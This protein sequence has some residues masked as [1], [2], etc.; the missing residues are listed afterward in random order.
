MTNRMLL[1]E[2]AA[3]RFRRDLYHRIGVTRI[4]PPPLRERHGDLELLVEHFNASLAE[5]HEVPP[6]RF[7]PEV[8]RLLAAYHWPGNVRELRNVVESLLLMSDMPDVRLDELAAGLRSEPIGP[9]PAVSEAPASLE[10]SERA[11]ITGAVRQCSGNLTAA[12]K[13]L[14]VSRST[15]YRKIERY[16]LQV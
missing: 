14:G 13:S 10:A 5:R 11:A 2:V 9:P 16:R 7:G 3:G 6:R 8:L 4:R 12:A 15:L 1:D